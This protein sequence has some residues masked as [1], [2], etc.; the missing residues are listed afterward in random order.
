MTWK[1]I[2]DY[3]AI[4]RN[5][6][7]DDNGNRTVPL[8]NNGAQ[9]RNRTGT[10]LPPRDFLTNYSFCCCFKKHLWSGLSLHRICI[11]K[12]RW[13][14]S[15]LYTFKTFVKLRSGLPSPLRVKVSPNLT[16]FTTKF[17]IVVLNLISRLRLPISPPGQ[18]VFYFLPIILLLK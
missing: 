18:M 10:V 4:T 2:K 16:P 17:P 12:R 3:F 13:V 5:D 15:S 6:N 14:P 11:H 9:G 1:T 7:K 8:K